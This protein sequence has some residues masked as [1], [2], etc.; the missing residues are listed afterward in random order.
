[1]IKYILNKMTKNSVRWSFNWHDWCPSEK[2][3]L[4]AS[5]CIQNDE[6][7]RLKKFVFRK[8]VKASLAGRLMMRKFINEYSSIPYDK[9]KLSRDENNRPILINNIN[10][11]INFNVSHQGNFTVIAGET[12][13]KKIGIDIMKLEYSGGKTLTEFFR[14]MK[15][16]FSANEW[17]EINGNSGTTD[18]EKISMF[19]R[20]W[21]LKESYVKALGIGIVIDLQNLDFHTNSKLC[22]DS[23]VNDTVLYYQGVKQNFTFQETMINSDHCVAVAIENID[24]TDLSN[25][26]QF[27][28]LNFH[29]LVEN[30]LPVSNEDQQFCDDYFRKIEKPSHMK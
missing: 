4:L 12:N 1:M 14:I 13:D 9:I 6:K 25:N 23:V 2:D 30:A 18:V 3:L 21:A 5:S 27:E 20:H 22:V 19:C 24:T 15:S 26:F 28:E 17:I 10:I 7:Q 29:H 11:P 16:N 8:D